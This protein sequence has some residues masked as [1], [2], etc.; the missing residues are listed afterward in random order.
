MQNRFERSAKRDLQLSDLRI[1]V[2]GSTAVVTFKQRYQTEK[3]QKHNLKTLHLRRELDHWTILK[4]TVQ[5][6]GAQG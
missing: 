1:Q 2:N 3:Y 4:E 6:L 5:P